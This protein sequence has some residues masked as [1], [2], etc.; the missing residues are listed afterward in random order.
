MAPRW[1]LLAL[2][3]LTTA[4]AAAWDETGHSIIIDSAVRRLPADMPDF[5]R[6]GMAVKRLRYLASE[7][8]RWRNMTMRPMGQLN[9]PDH[10]FDVELVEL[11][12]LTPETLPP[13]RYALLSHIAAYK[14]RHPEKDYQYDPAGDPEG[15]YGWPGFAPYRI[16]ELYV[17]LKS[18]W[19]TLNTYEKY[20]DVATETEL[21]AGRE[22][23]VYLMGIISHYVADV[24]Q[25]LHTTVHYDGWTGPNPNEYVTRKG[26]IHKLIDGGVID[27][28]NLTADRLPKDVP[29]IR[30]D[31]EKLFQQVVGFIQAS[32]R[33]V[34]EVY[35]LEKR[36][37][38][39]A[40]SEHF[41]EGTTL[42]ARQLE[43]GG[44]MLAAIW[45]SAHRDAGTDPFRERRLRE[46]R[47]RAQQNRAR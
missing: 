14:T 30:I 31:D 19:R 41:A 40:D 17:Q 34:E 1:L 15:K 6:T 18:S 33:H 8:D 28:A 10:Y 26:Y 7:P 4:P 36:G 21:R 20:R 3:M 32:H 25:P 38:F 47:E 16:C 39:E 22:N 9:S 2:V 24:A 23:I 11:Y 12:E 5:V 13:L 46:R 27:R 37:A 35:A 43:S 42:V 44:A 45:D 29:A